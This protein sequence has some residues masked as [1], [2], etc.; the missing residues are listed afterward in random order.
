MKLV[1]ASI[2]GIALVSCSMHA[3]KNLEKFRNNLDLN[4]MRNIQ[5]EIVGQSL[6]GKIT[7]SQ[8]RRF[9]TIVGI[10]GEQYLEAEYS[11][12]RKEFSEVYLSKWS[13]EQKKV[14]R[15]WYDYMSRKG[16]YGFE[17]RNEEIEVLIYLSADVQLVLLSDSA[18]KSAI[19]RC[20]EKVFNNQ[21][22]R[23]DVWIKVK[24]RVFIKTENR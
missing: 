2:L 20:D 15:Y 12:E 17:R 4:E 16:L 1:L 11:I 3:G 6:I 18:P 8:D 10:D 14:A 5:A 9:M 22:S 13:D 23:S 24:D 19:D 21:D 7:L